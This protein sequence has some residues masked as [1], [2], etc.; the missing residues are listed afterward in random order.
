MSWK[1]LVFDVPSF[2]VWNNLFHENF[3]IWLFYLKAKHSEDIVLIF[4]FFFELFRRGLRLL[5]MILEEEPFHFP[6]LPQ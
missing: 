2:P 5:W 3:L 6:H 4:V 1:H